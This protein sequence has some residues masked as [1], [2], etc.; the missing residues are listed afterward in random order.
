MSTPKRITW[1]RSRYGTLRGTVGG[2]EIASISQSTRR[3]DNTQHLRTDLPGYVS[4]KTAED[5]D[6][7]QDL[8]ETILA[9][10]V[11]KLGAEF[12]S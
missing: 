7:A 11:A 2:I 8:A 1:T 6:A 9:E 5:E 4:E 12:P 10:F 3:G